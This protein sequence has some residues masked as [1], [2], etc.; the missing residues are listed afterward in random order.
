MAA[1]WLFPPA[2]D[3]ACHDAW[4]WMNGLPENGG[5]KEKEREKKLDY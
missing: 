1:R 5:E 2:D 3:T 4:I